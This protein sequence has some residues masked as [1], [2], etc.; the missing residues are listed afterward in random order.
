MINFFRK[1]R[2]G[3]METNQKSKY[4]KYALGEIILVVI[5]ILIALSINNWNEIRKAKNEEQVYLLGLRDEFLFNQLALERV[6]KTNQKNLKS[7]LELI[8]YT[9][10]G[11]PALTEAQFD[12]LLYGAIV[13]EVQYLPSPGVLNEITN[14]GK[15]GNF[16]DLKLKTALASWESI[17][18]R[19]KFQEQEEVQRAR[20]GIINFLDDKANTR[21]AA[22]A[23]YGKVIGFE[24]T[25]FK[26]DNQSVLQNEE[27]ENRMLDFVFTSTFLKENYYPELKER[28]E[29]ILGLID[30]SIESNSKSE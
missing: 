28:I 6:S 1:I 3:L 27:F 22:Y 25:K 7:A 30:Q 23:Q 16:S 9:G 24:Q 13:N 18:T 26:G 5:G 20:L 12:S 21:R 4:I 2:K 29:L 8:K 11:I 10:P 17:L 14:S 15:L 19:I